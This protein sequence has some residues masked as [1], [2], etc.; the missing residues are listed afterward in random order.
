MLDIRGYPPVKKWSVLIA[1]VFTWLGLVG[2]F[3]PILGL[4]Q[5]DA[6][7]WIVL[8][9]GWALIPAVVLKMDVYEEI[10]LLLRSKR[11]RSKGAWTL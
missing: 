9:S 10:Q 3:G 2:Y 11:I 1:V 6:A 7:F 5:F 4:A 8:N